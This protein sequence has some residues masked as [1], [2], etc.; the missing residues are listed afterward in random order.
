MNIFAGLQKYATRYEVK[1]TRSFNTEELA[2]ISSAKVVASQYGMSVCFYM[3][4]GGQTY[5]P[6][7]R[8][9]ICQVGDVVDVTKAKILTLEKDGETINRIEI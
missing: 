5:V 4:A 3:K 2:Q 1:D 9:S 6:V 8:D 7:S